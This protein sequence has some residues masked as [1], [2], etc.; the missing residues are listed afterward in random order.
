M[1][2]EERLLVE[3]DCTRQDLGCATGVGRADEWVS[4]D[5]D[6]LSHCQEEPEF[7]LFSALA[8]RR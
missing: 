6:V 8:V 2:T 1:L 7:F 5:K 3:G 4:R